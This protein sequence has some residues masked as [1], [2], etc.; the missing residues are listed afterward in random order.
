MY[1]LTPIPSIM[2]IFWILD[3]NICVPNG[4]LFSTHKISLDISFLSSFIFILHKIL[5]GFFQ[6]FLLFFIFNQ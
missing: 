3:K 4:I 5:V 2:E 6:I 1:S